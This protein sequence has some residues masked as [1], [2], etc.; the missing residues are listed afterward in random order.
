MKIKYVQSESG[1]FQT[2]IDFIQMAPAE[3]EVYCSLYL[4]LTTNDG[5]ADGIRRRGTGCATER[6]LSALKKSGKYRSITRRGLFQME[7]TN[8]LL[9]ACNANGLSAHMSVFLLTLVC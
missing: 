1:A 9:S 6:I 5:R 2:D 3:R 8:L 4:F 7:T